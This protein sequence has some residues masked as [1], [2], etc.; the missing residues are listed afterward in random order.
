MQLGLV[1]LGRWAAT[2]PP[3]C[4][5]AGHEVVGFDHNP[6]VSDVPGLA[7]LVAALTPPRAVWVMVPAEV[8]QATIDAG[9]STWARTMS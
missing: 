6:D 8:T 9:P 4:G 7:E 3:G 2:W 5:T 1:G